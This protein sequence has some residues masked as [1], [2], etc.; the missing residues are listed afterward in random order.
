MTAPTDFVE[1]AR[2][3]LLRDLWR[4]DLDGPSLATAPIRFL[5]F[6][7]VVTEGF[8]R[9]ELLLRASALTYIAALSLV[10]AL[11]VVL[12]VLKGLG[13]TES[14]VATGI[15]YLA[16]PGAQE[17]VLP[18]VRDVNL[19]GFGTLGAGM[20]FVTTVLALRHA[21][22]ALNSL[23]GVVR[24]RSWVRRFTD[25]LAVLIVAPLLLAIALSLG[26][27]L[28]S[29]PLVKW[30]LQ[31]PAFEALYVTGLGYAPFFLLASAFTFLYWFL[32]NT[33]VRPAAAFLGGGVAAGLF[34]AA[35]TAYVGFAIGAAR[36]D[37][38]FGAAATL[39]LLLVWIYFSTAIFLLGAEMSFAYQN[40]AS[41]RRDVQG[42]PPNAAERESLAMCLALEVAR[43]FR[44]REGACTAEALALRLGVSV[45]VARDLL[46]LLERAEILS[47]V[48]PE[49]REPGYQ[50]GRPPGDIAI[51]D[52]LTAVR[53]SV[54]LPNATQQSPLDS[55]REIADLVDELSAVSS[56][57]AAGRS[58]ADLL[59]SL[60]PRATDA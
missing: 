8:I 48:T 4:K 36:Y 34:L 50:L 22:H 15:D 57:V 27:T 11:V 2:R 32:P 30:L 45:R 38:L 33:R 13:V 29:D 39:P 28:N 24:G 46:G 26:T 51:G 52:I 44:D 3:F 18:Y 40:L 23:W 7:Y 60:P 17:T 49:G 54:G 59:G 14:L 43:A 47:A 9:D 56:P 35:Q 16:I 37:A 1:R 53:G 58:L 10:P 12:A 41:Y 6:V 21:E 42:E 55:A 19:S 5:Q 31:Y 20:L 25:Y